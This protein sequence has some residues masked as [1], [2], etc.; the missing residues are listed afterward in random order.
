MIVTEAQAKESWCPLARCV[1]ADRNGNAIVGVAA[2]YN[3]GH[4]DGGVLPAARCIGSDCM[5]WRWDH[6]GTNERG[7]CGAFG[8]P[9]GA[10][11]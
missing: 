10:G 1:P 8:K 4:V 9:S 2:G 6:A 5:A 3:R 11:Q 7:Y